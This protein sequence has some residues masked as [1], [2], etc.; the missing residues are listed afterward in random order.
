M[1]TLSI[2]IPNSVHEAVKGLAAEDNISIN[3]F[4]SSAIMEKIT[5]LE[6]EDYLSK[7][8]QK[9]DANAFKTM[10]DLVPDVPANDFDK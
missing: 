10:L 2:R 6:T 7:R 8:A 4:I 1:S 5:A 3:Q 9:G